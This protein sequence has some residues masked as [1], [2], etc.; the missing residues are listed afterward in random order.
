[1]TWTPQLF[2]F[3]LKRRAMLHRQPDGQLGEL[4]PDSRLQHQPEDQASE[5][6]SAKSRPVARRFE[7]HKGCTAREGAA[8]RER[9]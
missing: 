6:L 1:V 5:I 2:E 7:F 9:G 4:A 3:A 8:G